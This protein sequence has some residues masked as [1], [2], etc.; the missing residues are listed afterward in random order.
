[1]SL[2]ELG[3]LLERSEALVVRER[4]DD[5]RDGIPRL[6]RSLAQ[7]EVDVQKVS[8]ARGAVGRNTVN[9]ARA[10]RL[11]AEYGF[12]TSTFN[13]NF[14]LANLD[15]LVESY[16]DFVSYVDLPSLLERNFEEGASETKTK[17]ENAAQNLYKKALDSRLE[18]DLAS[19]R[20]GLWNDIEQT[21]QHSSSKLDNFKA[22]RVKKQQAV[23][24]IDPDYFNV[25]KSFVTSGVN[26]NVDNPADALRRAV[27]DS[28]PHVAACFDLVAVL[29]YE[30]SRNTNLIRAARRVLEK[31]FRA[32]LEAKYPAIGSLRD[33][34]ALFLRTETPE[35]A[36]DDAGSSV[37]GSATLWPQI[38]FLLRC[39]AA[40][41]ALELLD[42]SYEDGGHYSGFLRNFVEN[43]ESL[44][45]ETLKEL[46]QEYSLRVVRGSDTY[47]KACYILL[48]RIDPLGEP[49]LSREDVHRLSKSVEDYLWLMM[50]CICTDEER[51]SV[52]KELQSHQLLLADL[53]AQIRGLGTQHFDPEGRRPFLF[54]WVL[55]LT[56]QFASSLEYLL[57]HGDVLNSVHLGLPLY[58]SKLLQTERQ[59]VGRAE[60]KLFDYELLL[61]EYSSGLA[62][63]CPA[64]AVYYAFLI[65]NRVKREE[66]LLKI[67]VEVKYV[68]VFL[69]RIN[70]ENVRIP[71]LLE[72]LATERPE[73][74]LDLAELASAA[75][76]K[77]AS[78]GDPYTALEIYFLEENDAAA[79]DLILP[80][81][82]LELFA[83]ASF[84][85]DQA[86]SY[87]RRLLGL[88]KGKHSDQTRGKGLFMRK[89][90]SLDVLVKVAQFLDLYRRNDKV[91]AWKALTEME[92]LPLHREELSNRVKD[93]AFGG[94]LRFDRL[95]TNVG[96]EIFAVAMDTL[97]TL[98][99]KEQVE[100]RKSKDNAARLRLQ[101]LEGV[102]K[103]MIA[104][105]SIM[106]YNGAEV[107]SLP[108]LLG[109]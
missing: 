23:V 80:G 71:G 17:A 87:S 58:Y 52:P 88:T 34:I 86:L 60:A 3:E 48:A 4:S 77:I 65:E 105:G 13:R 24:S 100:A 47:Q 67:L 51:L 9:E 10:V 61:D 72:E 78:S 36:D 70:E 11:L 57:A 28:D 68:G 93:M 38:F 109:I 49:Y 18:K 104:F 29:A 59:M 62:L 45:E 55:L 25:I 56:G 26:T 30:T 6:K 83:Q 64:E 69:G 99:L 40:G 106:K 44:E 14:K 85:R 63:S 15:G 96:G 98:L 73:L 22:T 50:F 103:T 43:E 42:Q 16:T 32:R 89:R 2:M 41:E 35:L 95:V 5:Y 107:Y 31:Q 81:M 37:G 74:K 33:S 90:R 84:D 39:G 46:I 108:V 27:H 79:L 102:A 19:A 7:I 20:S 97:H 21:L 8:A 53:Q 12:E 76:E 75:A 94:S 82:S 54:V 1:M 101:E 91:R 92:I 66:L